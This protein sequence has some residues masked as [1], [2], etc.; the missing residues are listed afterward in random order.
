[1]FL[2]SQNTEIVAAILLLR[3]QDIK[4]EKKLKKSYSLVE[5]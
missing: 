3:K 5:K 4:Q 1:M 2:A